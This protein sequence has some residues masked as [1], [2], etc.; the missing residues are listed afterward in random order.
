MKSNLLKSSFTNA[1]GVAVYCSLVAYIM[2]NGERLF[3]KMQNFWGPLSFL[4]LF[5]LS[6]AIV[7]SLVFGKPVVLYLEGKKNEAIKLLGYTVLWLFLGTLLLL[8]IQF[9]IKG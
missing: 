9:S 4:M 3:G 1:L 6:A 8:I 2:Q 7:G 5:V